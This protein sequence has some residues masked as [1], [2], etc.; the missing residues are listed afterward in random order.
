MYLCSTTVTWSLALLNSQ[1]TVSSTGGF[2]KCGSLVKHGESASLASA[3]VIVY[4]KIFTD[5]I[6]MV[7]VLTTK[8][9]CVVKT[10]VAI[11]AI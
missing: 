5:F 9:V 3:L 11:S 10:S 7:A 4:V 8:S 2:H 6:F 1:F